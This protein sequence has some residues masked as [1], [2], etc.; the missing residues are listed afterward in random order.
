MRRRVSEIRPTLEL[1][2]QWFSHA[3]PH[4]KWL[5]LRVIELLDKGVIAELPHDDKLIGNPETGFLGGG[6]ITSMI[7]AACGVSV[8]S[9]MRVPASKVGFEDSK[10]PYGFKNNAPQNL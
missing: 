6:V 9:V 10:H 2:N 1:I 8:F 3:V 4:N 5:G 7:D